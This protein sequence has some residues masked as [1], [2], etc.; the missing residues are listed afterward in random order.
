M[1]DWFLLQADSG[2][3]SGKIQTDIGS[4]FD[5]LTQ[6]GWLMLPIAI[7]SI[8][9]VAYSLERLMVL[10]RGGLVPRRLAEG[11]KASFASRDLIE[12]RELC[13]KNKS[14]LSVIVLAGLRRIDT[15]PLS[16]VEKTM[17]D[18]GLREVGKLRKNVR[19]LSMVAG[20]SPLLGLLGTIFGMIEAFNVV[21]GAGLGKQ[22]LLASGIAK[23]LVTTGAGLT[24]AIPAV[25]MYHHFMGKIQKLVLEIDEI[26]AGLVDSLP[27]SPVSIAAAVPP[28]I[29]ARVPVESSFEVQS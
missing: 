6:G 27:P 7:C 23:A 12:A 20:I 3:G 16:E 19:P 28:P 26:C 21:A 25:F 18:A 9:V 2:T 4:I 17:E 15:A 22:E 29:P 24:V 13:E 11:L 10:R 14:P 1:F 5:V 8:L